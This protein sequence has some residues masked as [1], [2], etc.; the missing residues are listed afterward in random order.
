M[1]HLQ[2]LQ[3]GGTIVCDGHVLKSQFIGVIVLNQNTLC[4]FTWSYYKHDSYFTVM[5]CRLYRDACIRWSYYT[6]SRQY[7]PPASCLVLQ[8]P[9]SSS[10]CWQWTLQPSL[11]HKQLFA[12]TCEPAPSHSPHGITVFTETA[13]WYHESDG[14]PTNK[15]QELF[16]L[17][18]F[19]YSSCFSSSFP[20]LFSSWYYL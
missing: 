17:F 6:N 5:Q 12:F 20:C 16:L 7:R 4:S 19:F 2:Q 18:I 15:D 10:R 9:A 11:Q 3:D 13:Q 1:L 8:V 14:A